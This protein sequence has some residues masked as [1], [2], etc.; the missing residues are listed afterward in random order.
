PQVGELVL[1]V[2][3]LAHELVV[4]GV[5]D[6]GLVE[7]VV[8]VV[9]L[10]QLVRELADALLRL[11]LGHVLPPARSTTRPTCAGGAGV[12]GGRGTRARGWRRRRAAGPRPAWPRAACSRWARIRRCA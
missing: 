4:G 1:E 10:A 8:A 6:R 5:R 9:V 11:A 2:R 3:Q 12:T 7:H